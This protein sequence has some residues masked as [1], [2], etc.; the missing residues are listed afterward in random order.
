MKHAI[1]HYFLRDASNDPK[2]RARANY[3]PGLHRDLER[4]GFST[5]G[6]IEAQA[7][8]M[9]RYASTLH[10]Y[11]NTGEAE[12]IIKF[13][14]QG[15]A[16]QITRSSDATTFGVVEPSRN[17]PVISLQT[18]FENGVVV[19]TA[20]RPS[21]LPRTVSAR[22]MD[23]TVRAI[24]GLVQLANTK[25]PIWPRSNWPK[26][27]FFVEW[28]DNRSARLLYER[29]RERVQQFRERYRTKLPRHD[30]LDTYRAI[31]MRSLQI[32]QRLSFWNNLLA[33][34]AVVLL[35]IFIFI[36]EFILGPAAGSTRLY[37][38]VVILFVSLF[39]LLGA[40]LFGRMIG[41]QIGARLTPLNILIQQQREEWGDD[42]EQ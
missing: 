3:D 6:V 11:T 8:R 41:P 28:T 4:L 38:M 7:R 33:F 22:R 16:V 20:L 25:P 14:T 37:D 30:S 35:V 19:E 9:Q 32:N 12:T 13:V 27:G 21:H 31:R 24:A 36:W 10:G 15:E 29:H 39:G 26:A 34:L 42:T 17:G 5:V 23:P 40:L 18:I 2:A 1:S